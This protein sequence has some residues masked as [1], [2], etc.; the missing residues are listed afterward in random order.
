MTNLLDA[1]HHGGAHIGSSE[2]ATTTKASRRSHYAD[3]P[4]DEPHT[5]LIAAA[6][7]EWE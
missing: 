2:L 7:S 3:Q 5:V 6:S 4:N 1:R